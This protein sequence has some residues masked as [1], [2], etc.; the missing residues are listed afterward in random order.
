M[1]KSICIILCLMLVLS[2]IPV[3]VFAQDIVLSDEGGSLKSG[4]YELNKDIT[5][6]SPLYIEDGETVSLKLNGHTLFGAEEGSVITVK[7]GAVLNL[8]EGKISG[9]TGSEDEDGYIFGG[10]LFIEEDASVNIYDVEFTGNDSQYAS[11]VYNKGNLVINSCSMYENHVEQSGVIYNEGTA[12]LDGTV[13]I[14]DNTSD[15]GAGAIFNSGKLSLGGNVTI[16]NNHAGGFAGGIVSLAAPENM[17]FT[18]GYYDISGNTI[19]GGKPADMIYSFWGTPLEF[20]VSGE[21]KEGSRIGLFFASE[22][23]ED[24]VFITS[25]SLQD[26]SGFFFANDSEYTVTSDEDGNV[27]VV[28][29]EPVRAT[30]F[31]SVK[32]SGIEFNLGL[33]KD[34]IKSYRN[35][36]YIYD[37]PE[38]DYFLA[39][40]VIFEGYSERR[41][42]IINGNT[43]LYLNGKS[44]QD[45]E[46][47]S[48]TLFEIGEDAA[49]AIYGDGTISGFSNV[50]DIC[51]GKLV[52]NGG[53]IVE[54]ECFGMGIIYVQAG[55]FE[56]NGGYIG[57]NTF[58]NWSN[59]VYVDEGAEFIMLGGKITDNI[60]DR[61]P[62][63]VQ[64]NGKVTLGGTAYIYGNKY[65]DYAVA[66]DSLTD[67]NLVLSNDAVINISAS[68]PLKSGAK[69]G[70]TIDDGDWDTQHDGGDVT[71]SNAAKS[72]FYSDDNH[73]HV[74]NKG[75]KVVLVP[76]E[77]ITINAQTTQYYKIGTANPKY[78]VTSDPEGLGGFKI[79]Y[80]E[81]V[82]DAKIT[83]VSPS[84]N[85]A[86]IYT[87][88]IER[89][90]DGIHAPVKEFAALVVGE[91][92]TIVYNIDNADSGSCPESQKGVEGETTYLP[93]Q[94]DIERKGYK[95]VGWNYDGDVRGPEWFIEYDAKIMNIIPA[96]D[97]DIVEQPTKANDYS[98]KLDTDDEITYQWQKQVKK[99]APLSLD[100]VY[101][102]DDELDNLENFHYDGNY[103]NMSM[104][105]TLLK[106]GDSISFTSDDDL[107]C[108]S[109]GAGTLTKKGNRYTYTFSDDW[110]DVR[111]ENVAQD[112]DIDFADCKVSYY[113]FEDIE[114]E[115][116]STL[117]K[118]ELG[119][120]YRCVIGFDDTEKYTDEITITKLSDVKDGA[121][122][123][124]AAYFCAERIVLPVKNKLFQPLTKVSKDQMVDAI[125][126]VSDKPD[127]IEKEI[128]DI[129]EDKKSITREEAVM[130][131]Y[132]LEQYEGGGFEGDW[133]FNLDYKDAEDIS[134][135]AF[136]AVAYFT[137]KG[138]LSGCGNGKFQPKTAITKSEVAK[139]MM[140]YASMK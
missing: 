10:G 20:T 124:K 77:E 65:L 118:A 42:I 25:S 51:G 58:Y 109:E 8:Y 57:K 2:M 108:Y 62:C 131:L 38:G 84:G 103:F 120:T 31:G 17:I 54:N 9:G 132:A 110:L 130:M 4:V 93:D 119:K 30:D 115:T 102:L 85:R 81:E 114:G 60:A 21:F 12:V 28:P 127:W 29:P 35:D 111:I 92:C 19:M 14:C 13:S 36:E 56:M 16:T 67:C 48:S 91:E 135:E 55:S 104:D 139:M 7:S 123:Q 11:A 129:V 18:G 52:L 75:G 49:L 138:V 39:E 101:D 23:T 117:K 97:L 121:W 44:I 72:Y 122:Y 15:I 134:E 136:E 32:Y 73:L 88:L 63:G 41:T 33:T 100:F 113:P 105:S 68:S 71:S 50:A 106:A 34:I 125:V 116:E 26:L 87:V 46:Y 70:V 45:A 64:V 86:G 6:Q 69:I 94:G 59:A 99:E 47:A 78:V 133:M 98:I 137:M 95:F 96:W 128:F 66:D 90:C 24:S 40:D 37:L 89:A 3:Y 5:L 53:N 126:K 82:E 79:S 107:I 140:E 76:Y 80:R 83:T 27:Y 112:G 43:R 61:D 74:E 22:E 1:K